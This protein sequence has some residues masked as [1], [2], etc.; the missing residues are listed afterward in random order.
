MSQFLYWLKPS[1][2]DREII[3]EGHQL[4]VELTGKL[5]AALSLNVP[6]E[7]LSDILQ[8]LID[9]TKNHFQKEE[10]IMEM[11]KYS[12]FKDH[13]E[14]HD[15]ILGEFLRIG[16]ILR[17]E[18]EPVTQA[19]SVCLKD[20]LMTHLVEEDPKYSKH[21]AEIREKLALLFGGMPC[22]NG[23]KTAIGP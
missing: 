20:Q 9:A 1:G 5:I 15:T 14:Q 7:N 21:L 4:L 10:E 19:L 3:D 13:K 22:G 18:E 16:A 8:E 23:A 2:V 17:A 11:A 12:D 6:R